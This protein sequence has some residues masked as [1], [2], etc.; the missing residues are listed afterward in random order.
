MPVISKSKYI[1][2]LQCHKLL[3]HLYNAK[4]LIPETDEAT[5]AIF[6]QGHEVGKLAQQVF[7]GGIDIQKENFNYKESIEDTKKVLDKRKPIYEAAF[8]TDKAYARVDILNPV[9]KNEWDIIEVKSTTEVK[10]V[11]RN[12]LALQRYVL[13]KCGL[14]IRNTVLMHINNEYMRKGKINPEKLFTLSDETK[15]V[16]GI[17]KKVE[18][19][20]DKMLKAIA[21]KKSPEVKIGGHC[22]DPYDCPLAEMCW[23]F[24]P[25]HNVTTLFYDQKVGAQ[26]MSQE[27][28]D[29]EKLPEDVE[30]SDT[31]TQQI[32]C[33]KTGTHYVEKDSVKNFLDKLEYP[34]HFLDFETIAPAIPLYD[35][36]CPY[37]EIPFQF[38]LV[39]IKS[40]GSEPEVINFL[41]ENKSDPRPQVLKLLKKHLGTK[42]SVIAYNAGF[43]KKVLRKTVKAY[44]AYS[45]WLASLEE[46]ITDFAS[47]FRSFHYYHP[48]QM[49][50]YSLKVVLPILVGKTYSDL[51]IQEGLQAG[52]EFM[53]VTYTETD[54]T[55]KEKVRTQLIEYCQRD[56]YG[57]V[58]IMEELIKIIA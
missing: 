48:G 15:A 24:L 10:D 33:I 2:G 11:H 28:Y 55:E 1:S 9:G 37:W 50:R 35:A 43:E 36:S 49:G 4:D 5:Q 30:L 52:R 16:K 41:S 17:L 32:E 13:E 22:S 25:K 51:E 39:K 7:P 29:L 53:R 54:K 8:A 58:E 45:L 27:I 42:G 21:Q 6:D 38:S 40:K 46:R 20:L 26:L 12:D 14:K 31:H 57:M 3:W 23:G 44:P 19:E 47:P 18:P 56:T 34:L